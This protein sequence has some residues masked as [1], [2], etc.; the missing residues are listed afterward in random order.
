MTDEPL[1][2]EVVEPTQG[3]VLM[4]TPG[5]G[6]GG[7]FEAV[8]S[9]I[10]KVL[11]DFTGE[12]PDGYAVA[13][14][15]KDRANLNALEK[16][17]VT[18]YQELKREY[19]K[20]VDDLDTWV[21]S[22]T[23]RIKE[24]SGVVD[25]YVKTA[26]DREK[27]DKRARLA[28]FYADMAGPIADAIPFERI[29][30]AAWMNKTTP[31]AK[32]EATIE[33]IIKRIIGDHAALDEMG[34]AYPLEALAKYNATLDISQAMAASKEKAAAI[35]AAEKLVAEKAEREAWAAEQ[36]AKKAEPV[37]PTMPLIAGLDFPAPP[38]APVLTTWTFTVAVT[39]EQH[40]AIVDA[41]K[42]LG[43]TG[44]FRVGGAS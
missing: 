8:E 6:I 17:L 13:D 32:A 38:S 7:N 31:V 30:E 14:A 11:A 40:T 5:L 23:A 22:Q 44:T 26:E 12:I 39:Q 27:A 29:E 9:Y 41:L 18:R 15:K 37:E 16:S 33:H 21:K 25:V 10:S 24:A 28:T 19:M 20:P 34:L 1:V 36:A 4:G 35:A 3:L 42:A 43:I 2:G